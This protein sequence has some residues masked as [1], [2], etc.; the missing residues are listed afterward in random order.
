MVLN[1]LEKY[2]GVTLYG[3]LQELWKAFTSKSTL[4]LKEIITSQYKGISYFTIPFILNDTESIK[5]LSK[6]LKIQVHKLPKLKS[7][8]K[9]NFF[10]DRLKKSFYNLVEIS[11]G[12][13]LEQPEC[14][15]GIFEYFAVNVPK[16]FDIVWTGFLADIDKFLK[17]YEKYEKEVFARDRNRSIPNIIERLKRKL[18]F[19]FLEEESWIIDRIKPKIRKVLESDSEVE[20]TDDSVR[21]A[22]V[23][24]G[25]A[26]GIRIQS[27]EEEKITSAYIKILPIDFNKALF[28]LN[29]DEEL[30]DDSISVISEVS[31]QSMNSD[32]K[33]SEFVGKIL[34]ELKIFHKKMSEEK[35]ELSNAS[36]LGAL[37]L[38]AAVTEYYIIVSEIELLLEQKFIEDKKGEVDTEELS[39]E[40][41]ENHNYSEL[42]A[43]FNLRTVSDESKAQLLDNLIILGNIDV[44]FKSDKFG[45]FYYIHLA[46]NIFNNIEAVKKIIEYMVGKKREQELGEFLYYGD[47]E[48]ADFKEYLLELGKQNKQVAKSFLTHFSI[49]YEEYEFT[50]VAL[51]ILEN[52]DEEEKEFASIF[53]LNLLSNILFTRFNPVRNHLITLKMDNLKKSSTGPNL[54]I[55]VNNLKRFFSIDLKFDLKKLNLAS[56][57]SNLNCFKRESM[58]HNFREKITMEEDFY[59]YLITKFKLD[60]PKNAMEKFNYPELL[61]VI[62]SDQNIVSY[63]TGDYFNPENPNLE[64]EEKNKIKARSTVLNLL[65]NGL[66]HFIRRVDL[67]KKTGKLPK[68]M[69]FLELK[70]QFEGELKEALDEFGFTYSV[71]LPVKK[72]LGELKAARKEEFELN[73]INGGQKVVGGDEAEAQALM[74]NM[75]KKEKLKNMRMKIRKL[76]RD[77]KEFLFGLSE[78]EV[79]YH[80]LKAQYDLEDGRKMKI[81]EDDTY[82]KSMI[83][84]HDHNQKMREIFEDIENDL[85]EAISPYY[86]L[87]QVMK[88]SREKVK[89]YKHLHL[90]WEKRCSRENKEKAKNYFEN[91]MKQ[92]TAKLNGMIRS[93][94]QT[95]S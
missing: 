91:R 85:E 75:E 9:R 59:Q 42:S 7:R 68:P 22:K 57:I 94:K 90:S 21:V 60:F 95:F 58:T 41:L 66:D 39:K 64:E 78:F 71:K 69:S 50:N 8:A 33:K 23:K 67:W 12:A 44:L 14:L 86:E 17:N 31:F 3:E 70:N 74:V 28:S 16:F 29:Y 93:G 26:R 40:I 4:K 37:I 83:E 84:C 30:I 34:D 47:Y 77:Q 25:T 79:E 24:K 20:I 54:E 49:N 61:K 10:K 5:K 55:I 15:A 72:S 45:N 89:K 6:L 76:M 11:L 43:F 19:K 27:F 82:S 36:K 65:E 92:R 13:S 63:I 62:F 80:S 56:N 87:D 53:C 48:K 18:N 2:F 35:I 73:K 81:F 88:E 1:S 46:E 38:K 51:E 32:I 52:L